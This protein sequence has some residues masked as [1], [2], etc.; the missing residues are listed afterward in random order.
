MAE[1][2]VGYRRIEGSERRAALGARRVGPADPNETFS[3]TIR[4]RRR[5]GAPALPDQN[6]WAAHPIGKRRIPHGRGT[7]RAIRRRPGRPGQ[8]S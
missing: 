8:S 4:V 5:P 6:Y 7:G 1:I 2:P 3:F